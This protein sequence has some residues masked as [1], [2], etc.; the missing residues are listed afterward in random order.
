ML[1][2][3]KSVRYGKRFPCSKNISL[4][5]GNRTLIHRENFKL[6]V[7]TSCST[8]LSGGPAKKRKEE[9]NREKEERRSWEM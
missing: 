4:V 8:S 9:R 2:L 3:R 6:Q 7:N 1:L 5:P